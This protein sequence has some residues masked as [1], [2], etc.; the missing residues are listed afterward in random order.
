[1]RKALPALLTFSLALLATPARAWG[2]GP[3][4]L[5]SRGQL[6]Q[7]LFNMIAIL[8]IVMFMIVFVWLVV[9]IVRFREGS[10]HGRATHEKERHNLKAEMAWT[11]IPLILVLYIGYAAYGGLVQLDHG[12]DS[13][14]ADVTVHITASQWDWAAS[15]GGNVTIHSSPDPTNGDVSAANT[16]WL[17]ADRTVAFNITSSD[18]IHAWQVIDSNRAFV[19]FVD[20]NPGGANKY[21]QQVVSLPAG[22]YLVQCNKMCANPGHAYMHAAIHVVPQPQYDMWLLHHQLAAKGPRAAVL[23]DYDATVTADGLSLTGNQTVVLGSRIILNV[24]NPTTQAVSLTWQGQPLVSAAK[25]GLGANTVP[26]G[27]QAFFAVDPQAVGA[28]ALGASVGTHSTHATFNVIKAELVKVNLGHFALDPNHIELKV[29]TTYLVQ[30]TNVHDTVHN[31][32][33]GTHGGEA[34]AHSDA[35]APGGV[36]S[37][38]VTPDA[39]GN[40]EMWCN[41][42]GH[43]DLG[44]HGTVT[45]K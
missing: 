17:P 29:G 3:E 6:V 1:M 7:G 18:V 39:A 24:T 16:F 44:M 34:K 25:S 36:A 21:N 32:F 13:K 26:P 27:G 41:I 38:L 30:V 12:L 22:D 20:A 8:G 14:N 11:F 42:P 5:T 19:M 43:F 10:G 9:I 23:A 4:P 28:Y 33:I 2:F 31:L 37:F 45:V 15:Y 40:Y 35:V